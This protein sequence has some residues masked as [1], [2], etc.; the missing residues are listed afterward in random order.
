MSIGR[1]KGRGVGN[2]RQPWTYKDGTGRFTGCGWVDVLVIKTSGREKTIGKTVFSARLREP[3]GHLG[4]KRVFVGN[5]LWLKENPKR[6][7]RNSSKERPVWRCS[8]KTQVK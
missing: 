1:G 3:P 7:R 8:E 4:T 6:D 2:R 5:S